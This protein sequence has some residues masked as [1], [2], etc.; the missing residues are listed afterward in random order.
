MRAGRVSHAFIAA[1]VLALAAPGAAGAHG[2]EHHDYEAVAKKMR[3]AAETEPKEHPAGGQPANTALEE[4][5]AGTRNDRAGRAPVPLAGG[6]P[7][8]IEP[9]F[10]LVAHTGERMSHESLRGTPLVLFFGYAGCESICDV[11][12]P[13]MAAAIDALGPAGEAV[14]PLMITV[15]PARDTPEA[16]AEAMPGWHPRLLGLTGSAEALAAARA[17]FQVQVTEVATDPLGRPI[18]AHGGFIYLIDA[19]GTVKSVLPPILGPERI[20][21]L[22]DKHLVPDGT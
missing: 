1:A 6:F 7:I 19:K 3:E 17:A 16:L 13:R 11:A 4:G 20:A 22:I 15:D 5:P 12:L 10:D 18:F 9:R 2:T 8:K 21:T 14:Q